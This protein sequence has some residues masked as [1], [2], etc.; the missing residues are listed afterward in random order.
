VRSRV[1]HCKGSYDS[2]SKITDI[3]DLKSKITIKQ[4]SLLFMSFSVSLAFF[5][6]N[7]H[8]VFLLFYMFQKRTVGL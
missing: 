1:R 8:C 4:R 3:K 7:L 2:E 5:Q 6:V